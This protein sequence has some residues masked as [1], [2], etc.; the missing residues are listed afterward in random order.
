MSFMTI[1]LTA[2]IIFGFWPITLNLTDFEFLADY[3]PE[4]TFLSANFIWLLFITRFWFFSLK[5]PGFILAA[6]VI[7]CC[8]IDIELKL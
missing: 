3:D 5:D 1:D 8:Y 2:F 4:R 7:F 6:A